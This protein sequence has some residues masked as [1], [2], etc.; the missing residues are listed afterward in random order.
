MTLEQTST[1]ESLNT[2]AAKITL[3][4]A[5]SSLNLA[6]SSANPWKD[7]TKDVGKEVDYDSFVET[8]QLCKFFYKTEPI[9]A[10][11]VNKLVEIGINDLTIS[12]EGLSE[13]EFRVFKALKPR[14]IEFAET[15]AQEYFL[16]GLVVPEIGYG[17]VEKDVIFD[18]GIKKYNRL[19]FPVSMWVRNPETVKINTSMMSD[20][21]SYYFVI[22]DE[23]ISFIKGKGKYPDGREDQD[24]FLKLKTYYPE[25]VKFVMRGDEEILLENPNVIRRK[26]LSDNPYP[27][28]FM[29]PVLDALQHKRKM[30]RVDYSLMDKMLGAIL[31]VKIGSDEFPVT[32]S[33]EDAMQVNDI[34]NQLNYRFMSDQYLE[35]IFQLITNHT[36]ELN[37]VFPDTELLRDTNK[38]DD[39]NQEILFGL[40]FPRVLITGEAQRTGTSDPEIALISPVRTLEAM[41]RKVIKVLREI[42]RN[43][44]IQNNFKPPYVYFKSLNLHA[45]KDFM[46]VLS[47]L[48]DSSAISRTSLAEAVGFDFM[49]EVDKLANEKEELDSRGLSGVGL[50]P[51]SSPNLNNNGDQTLPVENTD[52]QSQ[53]KPKKTTKNNGV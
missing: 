52:N 49:E 11:V 33:E 5:T 38:Y 30:R 36:V 51:F 48:Y 2:I 6:T 4:S 17:P 35:R 10:T 41:R 13:N 1:G 50:Q 15:M 53:E 45:F 39:I 14:L 31:H 37:W 29:S 28:P 12:K 34:R 21:P 9:I 44:A 16:S 19:I 46:D 20:Q 40:G 18:L 26:F 42:I 27:I 25:F 3:A 23:V 47:K 32:N 22:P 24:L 43:V 7:P 8:I